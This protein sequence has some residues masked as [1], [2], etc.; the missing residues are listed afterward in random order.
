MLSGS[1]ESVRDS[2]TTATVALH[3]RAG[4]A[5]NVTNTLCSLDFA[6]SWAFFLAFAAFC[7]NTNAP[8]VV[9]PHRHEDAATKGLARTCLSLLSM[10]VLSQSLRAIRPR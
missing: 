7:A 1:D 4:S 2:P 8:Q 9:T 5:N 3:S 10:S 6:Y